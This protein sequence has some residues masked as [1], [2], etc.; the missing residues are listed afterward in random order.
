MFIDSPQEKVLT[1]LAGLDWQDL[2]AYTAEPSKIL[3]NRQSMRN[4]LMDRAF[5]MK[6]RRLALGIDED[7]R[8]DD[9][10]WAGVSLEDPT[11][12]MVKAF[13]V[14]KSFRVQRY[15]LMA[16]LRRTLRLVRRRTGV[17]VHLPEVNLVWPYEEWP[18]PEPGEPYFFDADF[19]E[20][21]ED[22]EEEKIA[23][24]E[25]G[26]TWPITDWLEM[27]ET[28]QTEGERFAPQFKISLED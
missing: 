23:M 15:F 8:K 26:E 20:P 21:W 22:E 12:D 5:Y 3:W 14:S 27:N 19:R 10:C 1:E 9:P 28:A 6:K 4:R 24:D 2:P 25:L 16:E 17:A 13:M 7:P 11:E 18:E